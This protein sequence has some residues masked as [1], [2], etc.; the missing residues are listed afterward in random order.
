MRPFSS[1]SKYINNN[2]NY[3]SKKFIKKSSS[4]YQKIYSIHSDSEEENKNKSKSILREKRIKE[5]KNKIISL[6]RVFKGP[7]S[8]I[9]KGPKWPKVT[10]P[11]LPFSNIIKKDPEIVKNR[12]ISLKP[13]KLYHNFHTIQWL[14]KKYSDSVI[15]KSVFSI[16]PKKVNSKKYIN[17]PEN[18][19]RLRKMIEFL[20][21]IKGLTGKEKYTKINPKY[22]YNQETYDKIMKLKEIFL[23][24]DFSGTRKMEM[25][26]L[27]NLFNQNNIKA[28][29]EELVKLFF[30][31]KKIKKDDYLKLYLNFYQF[32]NFALTKEEAFRQFMRNVK[33]KYKNDNEK[34]ENKNE[35]LPMN[36]NLVLDYFITRGKERSSIE[37][38]EKALNDMDNLIK[39]NKDKG[40]KTSQK[41]LIFSDFQNKNDRHKT[42]KFNIKSQNNS[43]KDEIRNLSNRHLTYTSL[44]K[45]SR[46][47]LKILKKYETEDWDE[48]FDKIDFN[49]L[50]KE[51]ANLFNYN[52]LNG[53]I[54]NNEKNINNKKYVN[55][56]KKRIKNYNYNFYEIKN[57]NQDLHSLSFMNLNSINIS[58]KNTIKN[59]DSIFY[60]FGY[61]DNEVM[62]DL[63]KQQMNQNIILK[64][65]VQNYEKYHDI[66][67]AIDA[68]K[69]QIKQNIRNIKYNNSK[70]N[71]KSNV[72]NIKK[73]KY[74]LKNTIKKS[75]SQKTL[76]K[77]NMKNILKG[78]E[79]K[80]YNKNKFRTI[81]SLNKSK[82]LTNYRNNSAKI[83]KKRKHTQSD[84]NNNKNKCI[85]EINNYSRHC[86]SNRIFMNK[87]CGKS[88]FVNMSQVQTD[89]ASKSKF[90]YVPPELL[91]IQKDN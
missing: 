14:R 67:L 1:K 68:T 42:K 26:D 8:D 37:K 7:Q 33:E 10:R 16:L 88:Q 54:F 77:V 2:D 78:K 91:S 5:R 75:I 73:E 24:F 41:F 81:N 9:K 63:I 55:N 53:R 44:S 30:M 36:L 3:N 17:E 60:K 28:D 12:I 21:S 11:K 49:K 4:Y 84:I 85:S 50:I 6:K 61:D 57:K 90:D 82:K 62:G 83:F 79:I 45:G 70:I 59:D 20:Q 40:N 34:K 31:D 32:L 65:N 76:P 29:M 39:E 52:G 38:I 58:D 13:S 72:I 74:I 47:N 86:H 22:F 35:Y 64:M 89:F 46:R 80:N 71:N 48:N 56:L 18:K 27:L 69:K 43:I 19:K 87:F 66:K 25:N 51:F 23:Q 15:E